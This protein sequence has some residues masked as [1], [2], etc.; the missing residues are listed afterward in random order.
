[1]NGSHGS[2]KM[3]TSVFVSESQ[4]DKRTEGQ[5]THQ[6]LPFSQ[7]TKSVLTDCNFSFKR[8]IMSDTDTGRVIRH[9]E[10][11]LWCSS[12]STWPSF[13][14]VHPHMQS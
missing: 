1:M 6:H 3:T 12:K 13:L 2:Q 14:A 10:L 4:L 7:G 5:K 11:P 9:E 8:G